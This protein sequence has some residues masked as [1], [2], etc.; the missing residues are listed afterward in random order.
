MGETYGQ[1]S[2]RGARHRPRPRDPG[3]DHRPALCRPTSSSSSATAPAPPSCAGN[4]RW[5]SVPTPRPP[6]GATGWRGRHP[7]FQPGGA[8]PGRPDQTPPPGNHGPLSAGRDHDRLRVFRAPG[9]PPGRPALPVRGPSARH[10]LLPPPGPLDPIPQ[11]SLH[12]LGGGLHVQPGQRL[13]GDLLFPAAGQARGP[14]QGPAAPAAGDGARAGN[15]GTATTSW[16]TRA[17]PPSSAFCPSSGPS[18]PR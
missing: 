17:I 2:L 5:R 4:S 3:P 8:E 9:G 1:N 12:R 7:L 10:H 15:P 6:S 18:P 14:G 11:L 13:P 16:P